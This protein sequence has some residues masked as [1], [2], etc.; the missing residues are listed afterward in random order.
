MYDH[1]DYLDAPRVCASVRVG[2]LLPGDVVWAP[3]Q[4]PFNPW[5]EMVEIIAVGPTGWA[6]VRPVGGED[7]LGPEDTRWWPTDSLVYMARTMDET[8]VARRCRRS[9]ATEWDIP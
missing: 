6:R 9:P 4:G 1:D 8:A 5:R 7:I 3:D 2:D